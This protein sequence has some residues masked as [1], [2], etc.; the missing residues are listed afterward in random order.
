[1]KQ[2]DKPRV[3]V[4]MAT[5]NGEKYVAE[6]IE[7]ILHQKDVDV[8]LLISDDGSSDNTVKICSGYDDKNKNVRVQVNQKNKGLALNFMDMIYQTDSG[9]FNYFAFSDQDD[10]WLP[11]KLRE[12]IFCIEERPE[13]DSMPILYYSDV[14]N[15]SKDLDNPK[16]EYQKFKTIAN[17]LKPL[18]MCN[19]ASGCTMVFNSQLC[20]LIKKHP[21]QVFPRIHDSWVHLLALTMG[22]TIPDLDHSYIYRRI[23]GENQVGKRDFGSFTIQRLVKLIRG[24]RTKSAHELTRAAQLLYESCIDEM[25]ESSQETLEQ[26]ISG[27]K[28]L[29]SRLKL[30]LDPG[31][32]MP[33]WVDTLIVKL[34][35]ISGRS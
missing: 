3:L 18:L 28:S 12:A 22:E 9:S 27:Q 29:F 1:M 13:N 4:M 10:F 14:L 21:V 33:T 6:Q 30:A 23:T 31:Y 2:S 35:I 24:L 32:I 26:F 20:N 5:Y 11:N 15:V 17:Q 25:D 34:R 8:H 7:S 19:Y 16:P